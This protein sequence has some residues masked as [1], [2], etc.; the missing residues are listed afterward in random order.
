MLAHEVAHLV[1]GDLWTN[2]LLLTART[3]HWFNPVAWWTIREMQAE[4]EAACDELAVAALG[5]PDRSAYAS[6][7]IDLAASVAPSGMAPAMI[8]M[9]SSTRRLTA[10]IERLARSPT[11]TTLRAPIVGRRRAGD[12]P[13]GPDRRHAGR[14]G[15]SI[16]GEGRI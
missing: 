10:R 14:H 16:V 12:L 11:V 7:L 6:T 15:T 13:H 9:F 4:C 3:L 8:G 5:E 1:R 2:W